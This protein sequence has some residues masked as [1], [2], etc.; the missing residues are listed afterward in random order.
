MKYKEI[1]IAEEDLECDQIDTLNEAIKKHILDIGE[2]TP[3]TL[4][5]FTWRLY[6][7]M[8][9]SLLIHRLDSGSSMRCSYE[10]QRDC[11][12]SRGFGV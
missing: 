8:S 11:N 6:L 12:S 7:G 5:G 2:A 3:T 1:V 4:T 10:I 9:T